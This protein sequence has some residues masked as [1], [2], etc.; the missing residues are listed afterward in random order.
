MFGLSLVACRSS[1]PSVARDAAPPPPPTDAAPASPR[2][3]VIVLDEV[4]VQLRGAAET[5]LVGRTLG[6]ELARC[7]IEAGHVI[8]LATQAPPDHQPRS[9]RLRVE[10]AA[11]VHR[12]AKDCPTP[13][14]QTAV[15]MNAQLGWTRGDGPVPSAT[16]SGD[17]TPIDHHLDR[18]VIAVAQKLQEAV[19]ADLGAR[20]A[21]WSTPDLLP[22]LTGRDAAAALWALELVA[23]RPPA[24]GLMDAVVP[25]LDRGGPWR[26]AA[27]TALVALR[28]PRAVPALTAIADVAD[29][30]SVATI[31]E[32][33]T[34]IGGDDAR[35]FLEVL[36]SHSDQAVADHARD[37]LA[38][39]ARRAE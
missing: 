35:D 18:S 27:I 2:P 21:L 10:V 14:L 31:V 32:A 12:V 9:A 24:P 17:A 5:A 38:R 22:T 26:S 19:C 23:H 28:D 29:R 16:V 15:V 39:L 33:V 8:P 1:R 30:T 36:A 4:E 25:W 34:A 20:I 7:L 11:E 6:R 3:E 37:G 13:C